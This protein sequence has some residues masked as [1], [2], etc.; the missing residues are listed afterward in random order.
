ME[1]SARSLVD[2][3]IAWSAIDHDHG[4]RFNGHVFVLLFL[5]AGVLAWLIAEVLNDADRGVSPE[6][7]IRRVA[8]S[9][10]NDG[11]PWA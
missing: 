5:P 6:E 7:G 11:S 1:V 2:S 4:I 10:D 3:L 9:A 8:P